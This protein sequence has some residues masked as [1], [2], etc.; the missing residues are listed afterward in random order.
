MLWLK[1]H[2]IANMKYLIPCPL[3]HCKYWSQR[4]NTA[5]AYKI[6]LGSVISPFR[7]VAAAVAGEAKYTALEGLP[8][9]P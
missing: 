2:N 8:I 1:F 7:A 9:R 5:F 4:K 3:T 6:L